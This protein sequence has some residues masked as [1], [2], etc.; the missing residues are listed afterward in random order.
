[1]LREYPPVGEAVVLARE[2]RPGE[3]RLVAY[4]V[5]K[6][7]MAPDADRAR[8]FLA[9]RLPDHMVPAAFVILEWMPLTASGKINRR[10][11][12]APEGDDFQRGEHVPPRTPVERRL[13]EIWEEL[14]GVEEVGIEDNF[15]D[16]GGHSLLATQVVS[17]VRSDLGVE[18][19]LRTVFEHPTV[20]GL[21]QRLPGLDAGGLFLPPIERLGR[22]EGLPLSYAQ[23]R[24]WFID[25]LEG[26]SVHYNIPG[27]VRVHGRLDRE[28]FA[29]AFAGIVERHESL[30]TVFR[31]A[32]GTVV[33]VVQDGTGFRLQERDLCRLAAA[34]QESEVRRLMME[35]ARRPFDLS[36]DLMLRA[37]LLQLAEDEHVLLLTMH[38]IAS[39]GW[40]VGVLLREL[41]TLYAAYRA[42]AA[43]PLP[44]LAVQ[45]SDY[46]QWQP[47]WLH[48]E[49]LE[50][51]LR[52][53]RRQLADLPLVHAL[54]LDKPR[55]ARQG[56]EGGEHGQWLGA[57]L[58]DRMEAFCRDSGVTLFMLLQAAFSVLLGRYSG[59]VDIVVG[60][61]IAGRVHR[62]LEPLIGF[63]VSTLVLRTDLADNPR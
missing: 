41:G 13:C 8:E 60:S 25:R 62:D 5:G 10:A 56:F 31:E 57:E 39:D 36:R 49:V 44:P 20:A 17:R 33:Q 46:A 19:P 50:G 11:L 53:W 43:N 59:E 24:L 30:R 2:D 40:S 58:R 4:L 35:E 7:R 48:G 34:T 6:E 15:F 26:G 9:S 32:D 14:L 28:A 23:Q 1:M 45:Y 29:R 22:R 55:P 63:F 12:P 52:Y 37:E 51:Q 3:K 21:V 38:H 42:G 18:V 61:P 16:L 54:P 27:A 47:G